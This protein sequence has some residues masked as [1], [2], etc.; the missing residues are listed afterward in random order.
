M[1][2]KYLFG[3]C[4]LLISFYSVSTFSRTVE[5]WNLGSSDSN[6]VSPSIKE[7]AMPSSPSFVSR[8][9]VPL[10]PSSQ[11]IFITPYTSPAPTTVQAS[12][13]SEPVAVPH[14]AY[15]RPLK[16]EKSFTTA[17]FLLG[18]FLDYMKASNIKHKYSFGLGIEHQ[19]TGGRMMVSLQGRYSRY[20]LTYGRRVERFELNNHSSFSHGVTQLNQY[21]LAMDMKYGLKNITRFT[22]YLGGTFSYAYRHYERNSFV[23]SRF[24]NSYSNRDLRPLKQETQSHAFDVGPVVGLNV[25]ISEKFS[26]GLDARTLFNV[27][28]TNPKEVSFRHGKK[29]VPLEDM[30]RWVM[31]LKM[32]MGI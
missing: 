2:N 29:R 16:P 14:S 23:R 12:Q 27:G 4:T 11:P 22:P 15:V 18:G 19:M 7:K 25:Q 17:I 21:S 9:A 31:G 3:F 6:F 26:L 20:E 28:N 5:Q 13:F 24:Y 32:T 1:K 30:S 10:N 8:V